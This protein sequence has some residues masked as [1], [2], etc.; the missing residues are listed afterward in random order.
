MN[1]RI[2]LA[3]VA[4]GW[5]L[6]CVAVAQT[7]APT[8][9]PDFSTTRIVTNDLGNKTYMLAGAGGNMTF[10]IGSDAAFLVDTEYAPLH[11]KI[12]AAIAALTDNHVRYVLNTHFHGDHSGGDALFVKEGT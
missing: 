3:G 12:K 8:A 11:D 10:A 7:A 2:L 6:L 9:A 4:A 5:S 1:A